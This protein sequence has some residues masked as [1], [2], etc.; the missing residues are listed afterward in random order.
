MEVDERLHVVERDAVELKM[1]VTMLVAE[2]ETNR[3][4]MERAGQCWE[5]IRDVVVDQQGMITDL[6]NLVDLLREQI[7]AL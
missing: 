2:R 1:D 3:E 7:L 6:H 5:Q 4:Q